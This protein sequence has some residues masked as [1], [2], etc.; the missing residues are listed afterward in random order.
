MPTV[1]N[2]GGPSGGPSGNTVSGPPD[3]SQQIPPTP[4][5]MRQ[6]PTFTPPDPYV[7]S[8]GPRL[9]PYG[10]IISPRPGPGGYGPQ[11]AAGILDTYGLEVRPL[12]KTRTLTLHLNAVASSMTGKVLSDVINTAFT[13]KDIYFY[14]SSP[15][16]AS[17]MSGGL[18][19]QGNDAAVVQP[20][21]S[22]SSFIM[23]QSNSNSYNFNTLIPP[24]VAAIPMYDLNWYVD[25]QGSQLW[26]LFGNGDAAAA[27][28]LMVATIIIEQGTETIP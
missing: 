5:N 1:P 27:S 4:P 14:C 23:P 26:F 15:T 3:N 20:N 21:T 2:S 25:Q 12:R 11:Q 22:P 7:P 16:S 9:N 28:A 8:D 18:T 24:I 17:F 19:W 13:I 6:P 10:G